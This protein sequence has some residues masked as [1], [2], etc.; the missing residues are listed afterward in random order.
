VLGDIFDQT[1]DQE[2]ALRMFDAAAETLAD[3]RNPHLARAYE[4]KAAVLEAQGRKDEAL[5]ALKLALA[6]RAPNR[7]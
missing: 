6:A 2:A 7:V 5:D 4:R 1:G 3:H